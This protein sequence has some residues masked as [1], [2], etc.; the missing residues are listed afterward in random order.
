MHQTSGAGAH[1]AQQERRQMRVI[2]GLVVGLALRP[3]RFGTADRGDMRGGCRLRRRATA[4]MTRLT[5]APRLSVLTRLS[6]LARLTLGAGC[7]LGAGFAVLTRFAVLARLSVL[8]RLALAARL[9]AAAGTI[10]VTIAAARAAR[11]LG[12]VGRFA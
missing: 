2:A 10:P 9:A 3:P 6:V 5:F 1:R 12:L 7:L 4:T 11:G 8:T